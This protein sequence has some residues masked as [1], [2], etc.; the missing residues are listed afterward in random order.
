MGIISVA[1]GRFEEQTN[2][3][4]RSVAGERRKKG[5][6]LNLL[7]NAE[8][9]M[10]GKTFAFPTCLWEKGGKPDFHISSANNTFHC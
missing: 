9:R 3:R 5:Y 4:G 6:L 10:R 8:I 7:T 1:M 2:R